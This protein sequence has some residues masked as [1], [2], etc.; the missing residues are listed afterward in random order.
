MPFTIRHLG[1]T[2][3]GLWMLVASLTYY[4][5]LLDLGYGSSVVKQITEADAQGDPV[6]VNRILS[7]FVIVYGV[8]G[9]AAAPAIVARERRRGGGRSTAPAG[10][11]TTRYLETLKLSTCT[12]SR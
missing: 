5:Q 1:Q 10:C 6:R 9:I 8:I 7:T 12:S 2:E 4:F 11:Q 3:Y